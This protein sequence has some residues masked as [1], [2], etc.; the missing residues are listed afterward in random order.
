MG[1]VSREELVWKESLLAHHNVKS[2]RERTR[3]AFVSAQE[4]KPQAV[5]GSGRLDPRDLKKKGSENSRS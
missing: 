5:C 1:A 3:L 2:L 4:F